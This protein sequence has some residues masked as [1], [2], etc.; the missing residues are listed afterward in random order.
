MKIVNKSRKIIAINGEPLLPGATME[1]PKELVN[2]PSI[3]EYLAKG[4][5]ADA[6][7]AAD[8]VSAPGTISDEER[9][10]IAEE[11][12]AKYKAEQEAA[13]NAEQKAQADALAAEIKAVKKLKKE[14]LVTKALGMGI[15]VDD[16]DTTDDLK[17][18]IIT[19]LNANANA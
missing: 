8:A 5:V 11:A 1:L 13:A 12:I 6:L 9:A 3:K 19:A 17:D 14:E 7:A 4:V 18:K 10:K 15:A 2:H 16:G